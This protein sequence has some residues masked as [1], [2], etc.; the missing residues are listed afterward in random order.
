MAALR[1]AMNGAEV[2]LMHFTE[3]LA[4]EKTQTKPDPKIKTKPTWDRNVWQR[5]QE[6]TKGNGKNKL[7]G[8]AGGK[9]SGTGKSKSKGKGKGK[10]Q[11]G[12][13]VCGRTPDNRLLC[14]RWNDGEECDG[15]C[16]MVHACRVVGC[17]DTEHPM[18][19]HPGFNPN[20]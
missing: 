1:S 19:R 4:L 7:K 20:A 8:K 17:L 12:L 18:A 16:G 11:G 3:P 13:H 5:T 15:S 6:D 14:Y 9:G 10:L 2:R